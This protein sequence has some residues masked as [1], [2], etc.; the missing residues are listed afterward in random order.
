[1]DRFFLLHIFH[2]AGDDFIDEPEV[3]FFL[4]KYLKFLVILPMEALN[5]VSLPEILLSE[6]LYTI[7]NWS[8]TERLSKRHPLAT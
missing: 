6:S 1:M 3:F 5:N 7:V 8:F 2:V 4:S